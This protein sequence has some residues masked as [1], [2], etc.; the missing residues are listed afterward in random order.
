MEHVSL[1]NFALKMQKLGK[2]TFEER[3]KWLSRT[4]EIDAFGNIV[5]VDTYERVVSAS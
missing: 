5:Q 2:M 3:M 1:A 4:K